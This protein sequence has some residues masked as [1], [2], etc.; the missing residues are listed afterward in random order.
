MSLLS[1]AHLVAEGMVLSSTFRHVL[2]L[3]GAL[4]D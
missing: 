1:V 2:F 4:F 3:E